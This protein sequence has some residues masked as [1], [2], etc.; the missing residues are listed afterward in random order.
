[1]NYDVIII[2]GGPAG[3]SASLYTKRANLSTLILHES[4]SSLDKAE[5]I[6]NYYGF[7]KGISGKELY[8]TGIKQAENIGVEIKKE[9]VLKIEMSLEGFCIK[10]N[11]NEYTSKAVILA[12]GNK[13]NKP[14]IKG[15]DEFEGKGV[16]YCAVCDGFFYRNKDIT[17]LGNGDYAISETNELINIAKEITILTNG[18]EAPNFRA[19]NVKIDTRSI[20]EI[21][22][23]DR[24]EVIKFKDGEKLNTNGVFVAQGV[25]GST[26]FAKKL[27]AMT[28]KDK[29]VVNEKMET[30]ING[31]YACGDCTGGTLQIAKAV[32]QGMV[33]GMQTIKYVKKLGGK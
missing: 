7:A 23:E 9:E 16:S 21:Q 26:E 12:T 1:M 31:L 3:V 32:Y 30:N 2:G 8:D 33:A 13:K 19:D 27:G 18:L 17:V 24:V 22:G 4:I 11:N 6:E 15:I 10:T 25:A 28:E 5:K 20:D 29:I 14:N